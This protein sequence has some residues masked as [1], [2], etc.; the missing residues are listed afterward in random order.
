MRL[1]ALNGHI[2]KTLIRWT[3]LGNDIFRRGEI[4]PFDTFPKRYKGEI[5]SLRSQ[6][7]V[8]ECYYR[9]YSVI[10][11]PCSLFLWPRRSW[12]WRLW[13]DP[14]RLSWDCFVT[15]LRFVPRNDWSE[16]GVNAFICHC[17][18]M[19]LYYMAVAIAFSIIC[20]C[21]GAVYAT[22]AIAFM[23]F[24]SFYCF[25]PLMGVVS[26]GIIQLLRKPRLLCHSATLRSSQWRIKNL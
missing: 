14:H 5:A 19:H 7:P 13:V 21:K 20:H 24:S 15:P 25:C 18:A 9:I 16:E 1:R 10:A 2:E 8:E 17:E 3:F 11:R 23:I 22:A 12:F 4:T 6:W 26:K